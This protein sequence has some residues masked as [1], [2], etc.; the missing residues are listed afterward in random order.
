[1]TMTISEATTEDWIDFWQNEDVAPAT[2]TMKVADL[3]KM[4]DDLKEQ[5]A[6]AFCVWDM[7]QFEEDAICGMIDETFDEVLS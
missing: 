5:V 6:I 2:V 3:N 4:R 1:M 7:G